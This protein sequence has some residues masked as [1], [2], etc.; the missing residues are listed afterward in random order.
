MPVKMTDNTLYFGDNLD[1]LRMYVDDESVDLIYLDPPFNSNATYNVLFTEHSGEL[2]ASQI[3]AFEDTWVWDERS[4]ESF[5]EVV[6]LGGKLSE[7]MQAFYKILS[8]SNMM[9]YLSRMAPRLLELR[10]VLKSNGSIYLHCD[11]TASHYLKILMDSIF[12]AKQ[13]TSEIIW[14]RTFAHSG[15]KRYG[16]VHDVIFYYRKSEDYIWNS[17]MIDYSDSHRTNFFSKR[18]SNGATY[19]LRDLTGSGTRKGS[20]GKPWRGIDPN[21]SGRHW[22]VPGYSKNFIPNPDVETVQEL[23]DQLDA[24]GRIYWPQKKGGMPRFMQYLDDLEGVAVQDVWVDIPPISSQASERLGYPTQKPEAL[25][26]RIINSSSNKGDVVLDPFCGCGTAIAVAHELK[27][28]WIGIDITYLATN[29]IKHRLFDKF[30]GKIKDKYKVVGEPVSLPDAEALAEQDRYQF[31]WWALGLLGAR[32]TEKRKGADKGID[33]RLYFH[34][35]VNKTKQV[36]FSVKSGKVNVSHVRDLR[37]VVERENAEIGVLITLNPP[38]GP[39]RKEAST[40]GFYEPPEHV[41]KWKKRYQKIQILS[42]EEILNGKTIDMPPLLEVNVT[43]K[44]GAQAKREK[45][46]QELLDL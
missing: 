22:A 27:R 18:G 42:I 33:G 13:F 16:P 24:I 43:F 40:S 1:I 3:K 20:S 11:P 30:G 15:S 8:T 4:A 28:K 32:S 29:L 21:R 26:E 7:T 9:A 2:A 19:G 14:K 34:D 45:N 39:M 5:R 17:Q 36:V 10:R 41:A 6:E 31:Q 23:L 38:S 35:E 37:G 12:G 44:T 46:H 25:L